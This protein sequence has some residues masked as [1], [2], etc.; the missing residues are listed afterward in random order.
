MPPYTGP[1]CPW[2]PKEHSLASEVFL[3][4]Q[5]PSEFGHIKLEISEGN[6]GLYSSSLH[7]TVDYMMSFLRAGTMSV[8]CLY[9]WNRASATEGLWKD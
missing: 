6:I 9:S 3:S 2:T 4:G 5:L 8:S 1:C 7:D